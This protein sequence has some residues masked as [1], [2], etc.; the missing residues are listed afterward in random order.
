MAWLICPCICLI[1]R[2]K[3]WREKGRGGARL[4]KMCEF[5]IILM[6]G[7]S[8][9]RSLTICA[10]GGRLPGCW[11]A[12][13]CRAGRWWN[14][15]IQNQIVF[16]GILKRDIPQGSFEVLMCNL[17][18]R[19]WTPVTQGG[20]TTAVSAIQTQMSCHKTGTPPLFHI[21]YMATTPVFI[22]GK[23]KLRIGYEFGVVNGLD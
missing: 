14:K 3:Y 23:G 16:Q 1:R 8:G 21:A 15:L 10:P 13:G 19:V 17:C 9:S 22:G 11:L 12:S 7:Q 4:T 2:K 20:D 5:L 6:G 18:E